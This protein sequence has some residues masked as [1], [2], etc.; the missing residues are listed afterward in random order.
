[1]YEKVVE[2]VADLR[3][4]EALDSVRMALEAGIEPLRILDACQEAMGIVGRRFEQSV[5]FLPE[6]ILAGDLL[7][8][9]KKLLEPRLAASPPRQRLGRVVIGTVKGDIHNIGKDLVAFMLDANGFEVFDLGVD[10]PPQAFVDKAQEVGANIV[11]LSGLLTVAFE[12]MKATV[13]TFRQAGMRDKVRVMIGGA[14]VN[15]STKQYT[16]ADAW[17]VDAAEAVSLAR[18]WIQGS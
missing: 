13:E 5:Y 18:G 11:A 7:S 10:I 8:Q 4:E 16:G 9:I 1:M 17:G 12:P 15:E 3:E 14:P 2:A 6:L